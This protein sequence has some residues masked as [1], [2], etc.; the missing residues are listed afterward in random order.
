MALIVEDRVRDTSTSTGAGPTGFQTSGTAPSR[1]R[2]F[3]AS[4]VAIAVNDTFPYVIVHQT[5]NEWETG[6][7]TCTATSPFTF[8]RTTIYSSSNADAA[9][10]F[11]AGTKDVLLTFPAT[12]ALA[13]S[14]ELGHP[15][16]TTITRPSAGDIQ[17]EGNTV[18]RAGGTDV[19]VT[20]GGTGV[21]TLTGILQGNGTGAIT[22][23]PNS[24]TVGQA[25]RVTGA[26][27][28]AWGAIDLA[29]VDAIAN[30]L[31][32]A[33]L[34]QATARSVL[35]VAGNA[36][37]DV[38]SIQ[39]TTDQVLRVDTAGTGLGFGTVATG[40]ITN[41]AVTYA[42]IQN[43]SAT[44][45]V[46]GRI[47][48]GAGVVEE[49]TGANVKTIL[50]SGDITKTDDTNVTLTLGGTPTGALFS[51]TSFTLGWT[52]T[53]AAAR[54]NANVV[55]GIT[56]DTNVTGSISAQVLTLGWTGTLSVARGGTGA[57]TFTAN[58]VLYGNTTGAL[59]VTA[60]GAANTILT[61]NA[62][63]PSFSAS[64]TIGTQVTVPIVIGGTAAGSTLDLRSTS[65]AGTTD[66]MLFRTA[67]QTER[68]RIDNG[69]RF[70]SGATAARG[71]SGSTVPFLQQNGGV[72]GNYDETS[73]GLFN[74]G[75]N[76]TFPFYCFNKT[77]GG[78]IGTHG[79]LAL[80]DVVGAIFF[81]A[82]TGTTFGRVAEITILSAAASSA[83]STPGFMSFTTT[84][85]GST[86]PVPR[87]QISSTGACT[88][89]TI[90]TTAS[91]ANA[92]IDNAASNSL[93]RS[94][95]SIRYKKDI[96]P[97]EQS[98]IDAIADLR[99]IEFCSVAEADDPDARF[100]G[101]VA[102][103]VAEADRRL[104]CWDIEGR[105]DSVMYDRVL[106]L[107]V[108]ALRQRIE[109]LECNIVR[110]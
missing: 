76:G 63:A 53:L 78:S 86:S 107:Q 57:G 56:N 77:K 75:N 50:G 40:G 67:S 37:A 66:M 69:G 72:A 10:V 85:V 28:Y 74:W 94:T 4:G 73:V 84:S 36:T 26:S 103:D 59:Q 14:L 8:T 64:P 95:S 43:V 83:T 49:L 106:L 20:D 27:A 102:E 35:G 24:S 32:F 81:E 58:G 96:T 7:G 29:D 101:L 105:P 104:V 79:V 9:V 68:W 39:G 51:A 109:K 48:A 55:Q 89:N 88:F 23:I 82:S 42:K 17:I 11:S 45:R 3:T 100:V 30:R 108:E 38:A 60:Q 16:D 91:A 33:N 1:Y 18:Y 6:L 19:P 25:L 52:G 61:A 5:A 98:R 70:I 87:F 2:S 65:G 13:V 54:L 15:T 90:G 21:S 47:T 41:S 31:P 93:L 92:F 62:G 80:N 71:I 34:T 110:H 46:L 12:P 44:S 99:P 97:V 22:G